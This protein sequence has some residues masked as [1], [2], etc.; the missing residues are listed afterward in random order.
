MQNN[1]QEQNQKPQA[2]VEQPKSEQA[3]Q[4]PASGEVIGTFTTKI[5]DKKKERVNNIH[6]A[7]KSLHNVTLDPGQVF[8]FNDTVG[9]RTEERG[10]QKAYIFIG[11][12]K[13]L[14]HGGGICQISSTIYNTALGAQLQIVERHPHE[15]KVNYVPEGKDATVSY[16]NQDLKFKNTKP[17]AIILNVREE[18]GCIVAD[19]ICK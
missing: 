11:K 19:I 1:Q 16:G 8:S 5:L 10:Y 3:S 17:Y 2:S 13:K 9:E 6:L 14:G 4:T 12:E 7:I 18:E 15:K